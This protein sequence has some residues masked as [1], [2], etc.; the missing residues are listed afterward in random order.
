M[1]NLI[2]FL[3]IGINCSLFFLS[4]LPAWTAQGLFTITT[5][6]IGLSLSLFSKN[7][8]IRVIDKPLACLSIWIFISFLNSIY[9]KLINKDFEFFNV[10]LILCFLSILILYHLILNYI[11]KIHIVELMNLFR[12]IVIVTIIIGILQKL[13]LGQFF[14][15]F[16]NPLDSD[17]NNP[18]VGF[19]GNG[20]LNSNF[21]AVFSPLFLW[22]RKKFDYLIFTII[23]FMFFIG[24][25]VSTKISYSSFLIYFFVMMYMLRSVWIKLVVFLIA[26][27]AIGLAISSNL[28][29]NSLLNGRLEIWL[30][31]WSIFTH[32]T[33]KNVISGPLTGLGIGFVDIFSKYTNYPTAHHVHNEFFHFMIEIGIIGLGLILWLIYDL[34]NNKPTDNESK[35]LKCIICSFLINCFVNPVAHV[36]IFTVYITICYGLFK[37]LQAY[38]LEMLGDHAK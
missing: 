30:S 12:W 11:D 24:G 32:V 23:F 29:L 9:N 21:L 8:N 3:I 14:Y 38:N 37:L 19:I 34:L 28:S 2:R 13:N 10:S 18:V 1:F 26:I 6:F 15:T 35:I 17:I 22:K 31:Y 36:W 27:L 4:K 16:K 25:T 7:N 5:I 33:F 20:S